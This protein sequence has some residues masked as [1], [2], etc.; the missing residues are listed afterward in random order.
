MAFLVPVEFP[1]DLGLPSSPPPALRAAVRRRPAGPAL[2]LALFVLTLLTLAFSGGVYWEG[3][4]G[5]ARSFLD[6]FHPAFLAHTIAAGLPYALCVLAILGC[7]EMGHYLACRWYGIPA[8]LPFFIPGPPLVGTFGA[9]IRIRGRIPDRRALFDVAAAGPLAGFVVAVPIVA[10]GLWRAQVW[11]PDDVA[12]GSERL[13][14]PLV[15]V[16]L[17]WALGK[18]GI[19]QVNSWIGAGW[20]GMLVTS[21]N[22]FPVGQLDGGHAAYAVSR[23]LHRVLSLATPALVFGLVIAQVW[24]GQVPSYVV[25]L[26]V[27]L[28]MR[29]RHPVLLDETTP[30]GPGRRWLACVL[31]LIFALTFIFTPI[32]FGEG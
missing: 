10:V 30:L 29:A 13:G 20:V 23:R 7:H 16:L 5:H 18:D 28:W 32:S 3:L 25:W 26:L 14:E 17:A 27:L 12:A 31:A 6:L 11:N 22:L 1:R 15:M 2:H 4:G 21:L 8:T 24:R 19:L 9:V